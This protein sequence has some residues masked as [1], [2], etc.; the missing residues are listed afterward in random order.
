M[1]VSKALES[2]AVGFCHKYACS[3]D[4][5][6]FESSVEEFTFLRPNGGWI[7]VYKSIFDRMY[8]KSLEKMAAGKVSFVDGEAM[9]DDFEY[10][11]IRPY[12]KQHED[13]INHKPYVG[14]DRIT[15]LE[16]LDRLTREAPSNPV[17]LYTEK[18]KK[19]EITLPQMRNKAR[20][21]LGLDRAER[22]GYVEVAGCIQALENVN[23]GRSLFWRVFHPIRDAKEKR[24]ADIMK[25]AFIERVGGEEIYCARALEAYETYD[26]HKRVNAA[27]AESMIH[28]RE[29]MKRREKL[30]DA[31]RGTLRA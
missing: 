2:S 3:F 1:S 6:S 7:D 16:Y 20:Y 8:K 21:I 31:I 11:L 17:E 19:G 30:N 18:Y 23:K 25:K 13:T 29:E 26:A 4:F 24:D 22:E 5:R 14:M 15:R 10:T 27:L 28:A 9:L 12:A